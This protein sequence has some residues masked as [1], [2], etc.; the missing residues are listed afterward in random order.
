M[1]MKKRRKL[2]VNIWREKINTPL[3][4]KIAL[5]LVVILILFFFLFYTAEERR[6]MRIKFFGGF[7][8]WIYSEYTLAPSRKGMTGLQIYLKEREGDFIKKCG[9]LRIVLGIRTRTYFTGYN[10]YNCDY[11]DNFYP[12]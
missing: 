1:K 10:K 3:N 5:F 4:R 7:K 11:I 12:K 9:K 8:K 6:F 2:F